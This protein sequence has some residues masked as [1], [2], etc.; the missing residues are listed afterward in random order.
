MKR[1]KTKFANGVLV[2]PVSRIELRRQSRR[3]RRLLNL[4]NVAYLPV[5]RL[6]ETLQALLDDFEFFICRKTDLPKNVFASYVPSGHCIVIKEAFYDMACRDG[7]GF[8]RWTI[9]HEIS[10][11]ILHRNQ[12]QCLTRKLDLPHKPYEDSEWQADALTCELLIPNHLITPKMS[13]EEIMKEFGVTKA[14][15][16]HVL[17]LLTKNETRTSWDHKICNKTPSD[18]NIY[19]KDDH[20]SYTKQNCSRILSV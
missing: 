3:I 4:E 12:L 13:A 6:L 20:S 18:V 5:P 17:R 11:Y 9:V 15:A 8:A 16:E 2:T 14:A 10:H 1:K 19:Q 7:D